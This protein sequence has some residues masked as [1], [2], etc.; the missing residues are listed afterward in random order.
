[1]FQPYSI[2]TLARDRCWRILS[3][4]KTWEPLLEASILHDGFESR[5]FRAI[6]D[7]GAEVSLFEASMGA[8]LGLRIK[9]GPMES[10]QVA[11]S[12]GGAAVYFHRVRL[13]IAG[14]VLEIWGGFCYD[15]AVPA[16]LGRHGF[17]ENFKVT[18]DPKRKGM[19]VDRVSAE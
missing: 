14:H 19:Q 10:L 12:A 5:R 11:S 6:V 15:L 17:F 3:D 16:L 2:N 8:Q 7:S 13:N 1:V 4:G 9:D 18:F